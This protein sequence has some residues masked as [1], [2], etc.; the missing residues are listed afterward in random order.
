MCHVQPRPHDLT[1]PV[2][3]KRLLGRNRV[4]I[5]WPHRIRH[6]GRNQR[7]RRRKSVIRGSGGFGS[8]AASAWSV[9]PDRPWRPGLGFNRPMLH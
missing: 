2:G 9:T 7:G 3:C 6:R 4:A 5:E 8:R 1:A